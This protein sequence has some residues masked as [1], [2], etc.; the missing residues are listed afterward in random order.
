MVLKVLYKLRKHL[1][2]CFLSFCTMPGSLGIYK[3]YRLQS[4]DLSGLGTNWKL[5][6]TLNMLSLLAVLF[7]FNITAANFSR[8]IWTLSEVQW[9]TTNCLLSFLLRNILPL[10][11]L[12][13][14]ISYILWLLTVQTAAVFSFFFFFFFCGGGWCWYVDLMWIYFIALDIQING[15]F[16]D[17]WN[18]A[19]NKILVMMK[20]TMTLNTSNSNCAEL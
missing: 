12:K 2:E 3:T 1:T 9:R 17:L 18:L 8:G 6:D 13:S 20:N 14:G 15:A 11:S 5:E 16:Y 7:L 4:L 10:R 19:S